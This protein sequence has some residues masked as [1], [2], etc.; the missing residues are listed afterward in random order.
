VRAPR[1]HFTRISYC[2]RPARAKA[3]LTTLAQQCSPVNA[4]SSTLAC[5]RSQCS[6]VNARPCTFAHA[7]SSLQASGS[8]IQYVAVPDTPEGSILSSACQSRTGALDFIFTAPPA[9]QATVKLYFADASGAQRIVSIYVNDEK[10]GHDY[11]IGKSGTGGDMVE[12]AA[13]ISANGLLEIRIVPVGAN[14]AAVSGIQIYS[15]ADCQQPKPL[16][17]ET[18]GACSGGTQR[19]GTLN[20]IQNLQ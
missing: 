11:D 18:T 6:L 14:P 7:H 8:G 9:C 13:T 20:S 5:A 17:A 1:L 19:L 3:P 15:S 12:I 4:R 2:F 16:A 10:Q